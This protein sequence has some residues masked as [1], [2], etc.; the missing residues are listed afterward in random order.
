[1]FSKRQ[2][3]LIV[4]AAAVVTLGGGLLVYV[5]PAATKVDSAPVVDRPVIAD[6]ALITPWS[7][8][9]SPQAVDSGGIENDLDG[10]AASLYPSD[11]GL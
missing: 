6:D 10:N 9:L 11:A 7:T 4:F 3:R 1:M 5:T 8:Y 2:A